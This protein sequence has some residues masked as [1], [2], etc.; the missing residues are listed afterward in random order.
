MTIDA[1]LVTRKIALIMRDLDV[2]RTIFD[3]GRDLYL[4]NILDQAA[5]ERYLERAIGRMIDINYH[6][7]TE[8]GYPPPADYHASLTQ[9]AELKVLD[10]MLAHRI[11]RAAGLRNR[12]VHEY[13]VI[14][15][16]KVFEALEAG[17]RDVP[18]YLQMVNRRLE[19]AGRRNEA[20]P[21]T[22][23]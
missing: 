11:A 5:V 18:V 7:I 20:A 13:D 22:D 4:Q 9:L 21:R 8:S 2:L 16:G 1:E 15:A 19:D 10:P 3:K 14:D 12:L 6:L 17:L 23:E